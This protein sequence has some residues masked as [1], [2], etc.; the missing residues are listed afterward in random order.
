MA[1]FSD[2]L[3]LEV[4]D[5]LFGASSYSPPETMY[6]ALFTVAPT[7]AASSGTE[8]AGNNYSR[9]AVP[10]NTSNWNTAAGGQTSNKTAITF[11]VASG[12]WGTVVA[13]AWFDASSAGNMLA[14]ATLGTAK[15]VGSGQ[16]AQF[17]AGQL[18]ITLD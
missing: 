17:A 6:C 14:W 2:Y 4:L 12:S 5:H 11:P 7:D 16:A 18:V 8:V 9:V 15:V 1:G 10:N 13:F 3:E